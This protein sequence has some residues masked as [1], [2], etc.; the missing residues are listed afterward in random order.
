MPSFFIFIMLRFNIIFKLLYGTVFLV[1]VTLKVCMMTY[2]FFNELNKFYSLILILLIISIPILFVDSGKI[3][4]KTP[5]RFSDDYPDDVP[6]EEEGDYS[7][8]AS[9]NLN[10]KSFTLYKHL[11]IKLQ[12]L[13]GSN[14]FYTILMSVSILFISQLVL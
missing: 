6:I 5:A 1:H 7:T 14:M 12:L 2:V 13:T 4:T 3:K 10:Y 11:L 8:L 9:M